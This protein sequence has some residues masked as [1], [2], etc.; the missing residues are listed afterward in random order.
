[1]GRGG[2][3]KRAEGLIN[4]LPWKNGGG[5]GGVGANKHSG[6]SLLLQLFCYSKFPS[7]GFQLWQHALAFG[8]DA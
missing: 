1:M 6:L 8:F 3:L 5:G 4:F 2:G 7:L